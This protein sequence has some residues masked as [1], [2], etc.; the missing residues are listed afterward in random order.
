MFQEGMKIGRLVG[1]LQIRLTS[2]FKVDV[3]HILTAFL[4]AMVWK[5][6]LKI[7]DEIIRN[8]TVNMKEVSKIV[9]YNHLGHKMTGFYCTEGKELDFCR[10]PTCLHTMWR[11]FHSFWFFAFFYVCIGKKMISFSRQKL[12]NEPKYEFVNL[13]FWQL[14]VTIREEVVY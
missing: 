5:S 13:L 6:H 11:Q 9:E 3:L 7:S 8:M 14:S 2:F 4:K 1:T 12:K 10:V